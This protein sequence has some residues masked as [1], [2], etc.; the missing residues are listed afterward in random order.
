MPLAVVVAGAN[1]PDMK[2]T[3]PTLDALVMAA[4][5]D[6]EQPQ[7]SVLDKGYDYD[8]SATQPTCAATPAYPDPWRG[9]RYA[10]SLDPSSARGAGSSSGSI[11]GS[12]ARALLVSLG[13][14]ETDLHGVCSSGLR[15]PLLS[16]M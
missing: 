9:T 6:P 4:S 15:A 11:A 3:A 8:S 13:E 2:L 10:R 1:V 16:A 7:A 14:A 12:I 5:P